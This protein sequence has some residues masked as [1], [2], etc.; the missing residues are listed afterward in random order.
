MYPLDD[1]GTIELNALRAEWEDTEAITTN[2]SVERWRARARPRGVSAPMTTTT[3][4][5]APFL[6]VGVLRVA[7]L[8]CE[9]LLLKPGR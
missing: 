6:V 2:P 9:I 5:L 8:L 3:S 7:F 4:L 1:G